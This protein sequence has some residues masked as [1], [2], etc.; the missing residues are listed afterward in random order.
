[1][2]AAALAL[3]DEQGVEALSMPA[4]AARLDCGVMT[5]YGYVDSKEDLLQALWQRGLA[6]TRWPE[7]LPQDAADL[8][9]AWGRALRQTLLAHP[10]LAAI[11]LS[12]A[13]VG[14]V[15][16]YGIET[17]LRVLTAA[18]YAAGAAVH[19][20]YA[21]NTYTIGFVAWE[22]PR[23][24]RQPAARYAASWRQVYAGLPPEEFPLSGM[25]LADLGQVAGAAQFDLGLTALVAGLVA[26]DLAA[27]TGTRRSPP[28]R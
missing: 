2:V 8:L 11:F 23:T 10:S 26:R 5:L 25:V 16:F 20:I 13:V 6:D 24:L 14:P 27:P 18:G 9:L 17:M 7:P 28:A 1:V 3:V 19:A 21:V 22:A 12:Q 4:L 15:I